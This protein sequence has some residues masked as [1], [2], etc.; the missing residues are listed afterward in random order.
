MIFRIIWFA[1]ILAIATVTAG[2]QFD[3]QVRRTPAIAPVVPAPFRSAAQFQIAAKAIEAG[4]P[5]AALTEA[6]LLVARRPVPAEHLT[7]LA[8]A[9]V[10][11]GEAEAGSETIQY[12]ARRGWRDPVAQ[13]AMLRLAV[14][15]GDMP[16]ATHRFTALFLRDS[17]DDALL[18]EL[19]KAVF[20]EA[21]GPGQ[22][23]LITILSQT[24]RWPTTFLR[25]GFRV[26]APTTFVDITIGSIAKGVRF[27]CKLLKQ[28]VTALSRRD[29]QQG[30]RLAAA[31]APVC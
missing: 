6:R 30:N 19:S 4:D 17:T 21:G 25:R 11:A 9:L 3:R 24:D 28:I 31:V 1:A 26:M 5:D 22:Q 12:A 13:E 16:E 20:S 23:T 15:A 10:Q 29:P 2:V 14:A 7:V 8:I 18:E 27:D